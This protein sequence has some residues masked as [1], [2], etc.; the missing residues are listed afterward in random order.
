MTVFLPALF[1][2]SIERK[3]TG[4][5]LISDARGNCTHYFLK[6]DCGAWGMEITQGG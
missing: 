5:V 2:F 3:K 4:V 6:N 1:F